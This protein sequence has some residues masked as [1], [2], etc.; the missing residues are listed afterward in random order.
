MKIKH[1]FWYFLLLGSAFGFTPKQAVGEQRPTLASG[2]LEVTYSEEG[3]VKFRLFTEQALHY[4]N[5]DRTYP[6]GVRVE[7]YEPE[8]EEGLVA[9]GRADSVH[10]SAEKKEYTFR[11]NVRIKSMSEQKQLKTEEL[12]WHPET[13][14][15]HTTAFIRM[16]AGEELLTGEGLTA[17]QDLSHYSIPKPQ[18]MCRLESIK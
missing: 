10:F 3:Q 7:F 13:E 4:E 12:H 14:T 2:Q 8:A 6:A 9:V 18:G 16:E 5:G 15:L 17:K 11:G 1:Y